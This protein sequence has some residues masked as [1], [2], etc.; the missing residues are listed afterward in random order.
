[1]QFAD[2]ENPFVKFLYSCGKADMLE[3]VPTHS[4]TS[5]YG[6]CRHLDEHW[7]KQEDLYPG[8]KTIYIISIDGMDSKM[9]Y[10][11]W[12][13]NKYTCTPLVP[14]FMQND[15]AIILFDNSAEGHVDENIFKFISQVVHHYK[16]NPQ[17]TFYCNSSINI[18]HLQSKTQ[19]TNFKTISSNNFLED[20]LTELYE[21][22]QPKLQTFGQFDNNFL[23]DIDT[24][25]SKRYLFNCLNNA[26]KP[27]RAL[28]LGAIVESGLDGFYSSPT[29]PFSTLFE[30]C[31]EYLNKQM[32]N[33]SLTKEDFNTALRWLNILENKYPIILDKPDEDSI[34]MRKMSADNEFVNSL[35]DC[36]ISIVTESSI[37]DNLFVS[38]KVFKPIIMCQPFIVLGP[39]RINNYL[40]SLQYNTFDYIID[41]KKIDH[42]NNI[43]NKIKMILESLNNLN[44]VKSSP[45]EWKS[46]NDKLALDVIHNYNNFIVRKQQLHDAGLDNLEGFF[47]FRPGLKVPLS[48]K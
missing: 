10:D 20:S 15:D 37:D 18:E 32:R 44:I 4:K 39:N 45:V 41:T 17:K 29:V 5:M 23:F 11:I 6:M 40:E 3:H 13:H 36:D 27:Y 7:E 46:F 8:I 24:Q 19:Y 42:E 2:I 38:E 48:I 14:E 33:K 31:I 34:H 21:E 47:E 28:L 25:L 1:M 26:P 22:L 9:L 35:F 16:L 30:G 12:E 43:V